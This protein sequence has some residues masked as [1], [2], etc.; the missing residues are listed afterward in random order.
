MG[1]GNSGLREAGWN[2]P[3]TVLPIKMQN[4][5]KSSRFSSFS[6]LKRI[7]VSSPI[8]RAKLCY[9]WS[10]SIPLHLIPY[11]VRF[12]TIFDNKMAAFTNLAMKFEYHWVSLIHFRMDLVNMIP[13]QSIHGFSADFVHWKL[14]DFPMELARF[15]T[16]RTSSCQKLQGEDE[17]SSSTVELK[18]LQGLNDNHSECLLA[19]G[20][21]SIFFLSPCYPLVMTFT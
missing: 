18:L 19:K 5:S 10:D 14:D 9:F 1:G 2:C 21:S 11:S 13:Y 7:G 4:P 8:W 12:H 6:P 3:Q 17:G 20:A 15:T 16:P